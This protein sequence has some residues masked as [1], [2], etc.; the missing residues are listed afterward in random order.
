VDMHATDLVGI[1]GI[2]RVLL[3]YTCHQGVYRRGHVQP[4]RLQRIFLA[5][6]NLIT[7]R[8]SQ[9]AGFSIFILISRQNGDLINIE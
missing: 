8:I 9:L 7:D 4:L 1:N 5:F 6:K 2:I 3:I